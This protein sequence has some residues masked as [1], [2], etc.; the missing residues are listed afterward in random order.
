MMMMMMITYGLRL[1]V[2]MVIQLTGTASI[3]AL[4]LRQSQLTVAVLTPA[5]SWQDTVLSQTHCHRNL[6]LSGEQ[7]AK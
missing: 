2:Q 1:Q 4:P 3:V 5:T 6:S 7:F